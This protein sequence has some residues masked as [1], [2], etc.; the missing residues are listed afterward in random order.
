MI[1]CLDACHM[2]QI[3]AKPVILQ[4]TLRFAMPSQK[5][6]S[7]HHIQQSK[8][9]Q[10]IQIQQITPGAG[11]QSFVTTAHQS[12]ASSNADSFLQQIKPK[13]SNLPHHSMVTLTNNQDSLQLVTKPNISA[14]AQ[15]QPQ[16]S[17]PLS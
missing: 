10:R 1:K 4:P 13:L 12:N 8:Q 6:A 2:D 7:S 15:T 16:R 3:K 17:A 5:Q 11:T 9:F 14:S